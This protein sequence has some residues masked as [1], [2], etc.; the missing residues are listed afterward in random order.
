MFV[1]KD[2]PDIRFLKMNTFFIVT[3]CVFACLSQKSEAWA[4]FQPPK[5]F[6]SKPPVVYQAGQTATFRCQGSLRWVT[7]FMPPDAGDSIKRRTSINH[8]NSHENFIAELTI[9]D[10]QFNDTGTLTCAYNGTEDLEAIDK[11]SKIHL[12]VEDKEHPLKM[13]GFEYFRPV[14][15]SSFILPCIPTSPEV[16]V[17]LWR[18]NRRIVDDDYISFDQKVNRISKCVLILM[19]SGLCV[20]RWCPLWIAWHLFICS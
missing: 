17:S 19:H 14:Q 8:V 3:L 2:A 10:L 12:F 9:R 20:L 6:P 13:T 7:W 4:E 16:N 15:S 18:N 5:I 1:R 11:S